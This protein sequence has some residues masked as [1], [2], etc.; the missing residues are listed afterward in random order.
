MNTPAQ[1]APPLSLTGPGQIGTPASSILTR[2]YGRADLLNRAAIA[3]PITARLQ[4]VNTAAMRAEQ[5]TEIETIRVAGKPGF[6]ETVPPEM[7]TATGTGSRLGPRI[8]FPQ[9]GNLLDGCEDKKYQLSNSFQEGSFLDGG[10]T[11]PRSKAL[12][13][14]SCYYSTHIPQLIKI[15]CISARHC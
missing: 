13:P 8:L 3:F 11:E 1:S 5:T 7:A 14:G 10:G 9:A 12:S 2:F 15:I 4:T 6:D